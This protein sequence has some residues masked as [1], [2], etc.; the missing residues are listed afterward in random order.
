MN[1]G[2][3]YSIFFSLFLPTMGVL[4]YPFSKEYMSYVASTKFQ[5]VLIII[6]KIIKL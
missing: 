6:G 2:S 5:I 3:F 1:H 4:F